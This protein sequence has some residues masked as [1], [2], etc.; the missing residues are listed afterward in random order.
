MEGEG[1]A[2]YLRQA[3]GHLPN[4]RAVRITLALA[5]H[6]VQAAGS[7]ARTGTHV[8]PATERPPHNAVRCCS[9]PGYE[10]I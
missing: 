9:R 1:G 2:C 6:S 5:K 8:R 3:P 4:T 7:S 10:S